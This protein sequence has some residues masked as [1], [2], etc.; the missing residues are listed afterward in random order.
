MLYFTVS[1][2]QRPVQNLALIIPFF[3]VG[4]LLSVQPLVQWITDLAMLVVVVFTGHQSK[5][6]IPG[7]S[8]GKSADNSK[9]W[10]HFALYIA[11]PLLVCTGKSAQ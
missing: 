7:V 10:L 3:F 2:E 5:E 11:H 8:C 9:Y 6:A 4:T 1:T